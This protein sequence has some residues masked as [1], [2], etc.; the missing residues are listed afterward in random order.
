MIRLLES[1]QELRNAETLQVIDRHR[2]LATVLA[3][4][5]TVF[6][7]SYPFALVAHLPRSEMNP[8]IPPKGLNILLGEIS[9]VLLDLITLQPPKAMRAFFE[10]QIE[11][12]SLE[13]FNR[14]TLSF[15]QVASSILAYDAFPK[16][17]TNTAIL[18]LTSILKFTDQITKVMIRGLPTSFG[19][20]AFNI[21]L[22]RAAFTTVFALVSSDQLVIESFGPQVSRWLVVCALTMLLY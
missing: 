12:E 9:I 19:S 15:F 4:V 6:P 2:S 14:T 10:E 1:Y 21:E 7:S 18:A 3:P 8:T 11:L 16:T 22:W 20:V 5:P 13:H 17:W